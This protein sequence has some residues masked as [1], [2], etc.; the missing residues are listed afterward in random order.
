MLEGDAVFCY[1]DAESFSATAHSTK[2]TGDAL[3]R[4]AC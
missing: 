2:N 4:R 1:A 3:C